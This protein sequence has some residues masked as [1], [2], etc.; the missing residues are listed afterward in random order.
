[1]EDRAVILDLEARLNN[2]DN[3]DLKNQK[4]K[5]HIAQSLPV[6]AMRNFNF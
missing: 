4:A 6:I 5:E 3:G 1:M 2:D